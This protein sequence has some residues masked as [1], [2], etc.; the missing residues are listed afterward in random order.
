[1]KRK[2]KIYSRPKRPFDKQ[3]IEE[4]NE[5]KKKYGLK[6]KREIWKADARI[7]KIRNQAKKLITSSPIEQKALIDRIN[8]IG[9][10]VKDLSDILSLD[11]T[12]WFDRRLQ[13]IIVKRKLANTP[14]HAR[15]LIVHKKIIVD[16]DVVSVPSYVVPVSLE[17]KIHIK[18]KEVKIVKSVEASE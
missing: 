14:R 2:H 17:N 3:R 13:T 18:K 4:E 15:Q 6:N 12:D 11:K 10:Q 7:S 8:G 1:M 5:L 16:G 9:I